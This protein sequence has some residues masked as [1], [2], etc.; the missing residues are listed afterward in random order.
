MSTTPV[1]V[2]CPGCG[3]PAA[4]AYAQQAFCGTDDCKV[5]TWNPSKTLD[6][7]LENYHRV[8]LPDL[9]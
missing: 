9:G 2:H 8:D 4:V 1:G 7:N 6:E 3:Q 5:I